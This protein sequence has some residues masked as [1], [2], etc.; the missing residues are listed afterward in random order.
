M[1]KMNSNILILGDICVDRYFFGSVEKISP[2]APVPVLKCTK[3]ED[4][5]GMSGNVALNLKTLGH[6]ITIMGKCGTITRKLLRNNNIL[7]SYTL[8]SGDIIKN[9]YICNNYQLLRMDE[10]EIKTLS[11]SDEEYFIENDKLVKDIV[12]ISDYCKGN[13]TKDLIEMASK[14]CIYLLIDPC[15]NA[16]LE[17]YAFSPYC[18]FP[19]KKEAEKLTGITIGSKED[20]LKACNYIKKKTDCQYVLLKLSENGMCFYKDQENHQFIEALS[21]NPVDVTGAGDTVIATFA[22]ALINKQKPEECA[23]LANI[24]ASKVVEKQGTSV[25]TWDEL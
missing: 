23:R 14:R 21:K 13:V 11:K 12:I 1:G 10:E 16:T 7:R 18:M 20:V 24:S 19:N 25:V 2:E 5:L 6:D 8:H 22:S 17:K 9:R 15:S 3:I 4:R